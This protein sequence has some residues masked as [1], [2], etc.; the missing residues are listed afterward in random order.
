MKIEHL[1]IFFYTLFDLLIRGA[2]VPQNIIQH[3]NMIKRA[4]VCV[5]L[6]SL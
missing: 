5:V 1:C 3:T 2:K 6:S 4:N